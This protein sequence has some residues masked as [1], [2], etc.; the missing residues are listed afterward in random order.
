MTGRR[1]QQQRSWYKCGRP[2][3]ST[4]LQLS[5]HMHCTCLLVV[6]H[7]PEVGDVGKA[8]GEG[9]LRGAAVQWPLHQRVVNC[10]IAGMLSLA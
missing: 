8:L 4:Q 6:G 9:E 10:H 7:R 2:V 5:C 1:Q 3:D